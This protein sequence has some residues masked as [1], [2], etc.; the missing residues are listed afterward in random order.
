MRFWVM[1]GLAG[2]AAL[3]LA[4][5]NKAGSAG[6]GA[7]SSAAAGAGPAAPPGP[8]TPDQIPHRK[9][10]LWKLTMSMDGAQPGPGGMQ[11][12]VDAASEAR[13]SFAAQ[14]MP[15]ARC[16]TPQF[17]RNL[18][19]SLSFTGG[20]N[21]GPNGKVQSTGVVTGDFNSSY[22]STIKSVTS[23]GPM[24][25]M[26]GNH[27]MVVTATWTGPCAPGQVGGDIILANG[28]KVHPHQAEA[29]GGE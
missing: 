21:M 1:A 8:L 12:C 14:H 20:C 15:N 18:D 6:G 4:A 9:P 3:S 27:T 22:T 19:G 11:V 29:G 2:L 23:G 13:E 7:A 26:N 16:D 5:C 10:G 25:D 17:T 28:M 24:A